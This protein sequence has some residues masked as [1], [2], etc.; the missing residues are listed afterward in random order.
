MKE[1]AYKQKIYIIIGFIIVLCII[2]LVSVFVGLSQ[3]GGNDKVN[4]TITE[5]TWNQNSNSNENTKK[6][7][8]KKNDIIKINSSWNQEIT[9]E[10]IDIKNKSITIKTSQ[11]MSLRYDENSGINLKSKETKFII[12]KNNQVILD[13]PTMDVGA[14]Y[15]IE[16][17]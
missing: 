12:N 7:E 8:A 6:F 1:L 5:T 17:K 11:V 14:S 2:C 4:I 3:K 16:I 9:F 13:T 10:I 15:K